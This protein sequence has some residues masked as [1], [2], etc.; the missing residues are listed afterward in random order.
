MCEKQW[1]HSEKHSEKQCDQFVSIVHA[2]QHV[3]YASA[4]LVDPDA[5]AAICVVREVDKHVAAARAELGRVILVEQDRE[6]S[7][8]HEVNERPSKLLPPDVRH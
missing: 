8:W 2:R 3:T 6:A 4:S 5:L 1:K 7:H